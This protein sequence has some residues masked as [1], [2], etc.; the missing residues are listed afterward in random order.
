MKY[1]RLAIA[2]LLTALLSGCVPMAT[3]MPAAEGAAGAPAVQ[4][5]S[6]TGFPFSITDDLGREVTIDELPQRLVSLAPS[7]TEVLFAVGAGPQVVGVTE[8]CDY[9]PEA[10]SKDKIGGFSAKTISVEKIVSLKPDLVLAAGAIHQPIID[11]LVAIDIPVVAIDP[12]DIDAVYESLQLAGRLTGHGEDAARLAGEMKRRIDAV[13]L[14]ARAIP[15]EERLRVYWQIW[16]EPLMTA[17]P[18]TFAG[19]MVELAGGINIFAELT[20]S[21]PTISAEEVVKRDPDV[22]MGPDTHG[23]KLQPEAFRQRPGWSEI[24]AVRDGRIHL[25]EGNIVSRT[26]PRLADALEAVAVA[27]YPDLYE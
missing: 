18:S 26:G 17:G 7:L 9:P 16:D 20:G 8:Y 2:I 15:P 21:Y 27:L 3:P 25:I 10:L 5:A 19:Q 13:V 4:Q 11:A 22:I 14:A 12:S 1:G 23:D 6:P 24:K